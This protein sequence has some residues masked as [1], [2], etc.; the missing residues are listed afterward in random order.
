MLQFTALGDPSALTFM[1]VGQLSQRPLVPTF[2]VLPSAAPDLHMLTKVFF[3]SAGCPG[4]QSPRYLEG[5][6]HYEGSGKHRL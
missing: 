3:R 4:A 1:V 5:V 2:H 6:L